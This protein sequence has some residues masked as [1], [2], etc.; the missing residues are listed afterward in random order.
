MTKAKRNAASTAKDLGT[1]QIPIRAA[2]GR[3]KLILLLGRGSRGK[4][5]LARWMLGRAEDAGRE[6]LAGD[7]DR[8]NQTLARSYRHTVSPPSADDA[9]VRGWVAGLV[10]A[11]I[12]DRFNLVLDM[13][14]GD[15][16]VKALAREM[17]LLPWLTGLGIDLVA[18]HV[19]GP[20]GDD[21]A[22]V[23]SVEEGGLLASPYTA[24]VLN[25]GVVPLGR[26]PHAAFSESVQA[27]PIFAATVGR[28]ACIVSMPRLEPAPDLEERGIPFS[29]AAQG[30]A[31]PG[32]TPLG[33]WKAQ[34][35]LLWLRRMEER[36]ASISEWLP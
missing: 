35:T 34:Q 16:T 11:Q 3:P 20:A 10:E 9:E 24:L 15:L 30:L 13:G 4:T 23:E 6:T 17:E 19:I 1:G 8:T 31:P 12:R 26:S 7:G 28:G 5:L 21:V 2:E 18:V 36:F 22:Y 33:P 29:L 14:G 25:E 27:H 32:V